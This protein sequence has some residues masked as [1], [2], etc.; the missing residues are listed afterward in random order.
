[1]VSSVSKSFFVE[2]SGRVK[3][4][5]STTKRF[6]CSASQQILVRETRTAKTM[7]MSGLGGG[8]VR[9]KTVQKT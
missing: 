7:P 5:A 9:R 2:A 4:H 6:I 8:V 3:F 1:M